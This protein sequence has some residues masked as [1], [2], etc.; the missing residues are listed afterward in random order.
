[1]RCA[2]KGQ[3]NGLSS[4]LERNLEPR[5]IQLVNHHIY[6]NTTT[7]RTYLLLPPPFPLI[8]HA[9]YVIHP[10]LIVLD[11]G[12]KIILVLFHKINNVLSYLPVILWLSS[13]LIS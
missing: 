3:M 13:E 9:R 1:M 7:R 11:K 2:M 6:P 4:S 5:A 12:G 10:L 8:P